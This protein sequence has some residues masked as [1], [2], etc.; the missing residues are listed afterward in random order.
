MPLILEKEWNLNSVVVGIEGGIIF[1]GFFVGTI[2][3]SLG[4]VYG[5]KKMF[6]I[7]VFLI[8][9]GGL[10]SAFMPEIWSYLV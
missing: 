4:D 7:A 5:R 2:L 10:S 9:L 3:G 8:S 1:L 6:Q